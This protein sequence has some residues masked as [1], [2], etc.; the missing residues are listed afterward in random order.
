MVH[1]DALCHVFKN[2]INGKTNSEFVDNTWSQFTKEIF[3]FYLS[4]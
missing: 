2:A 1:M 3:Y 4:I